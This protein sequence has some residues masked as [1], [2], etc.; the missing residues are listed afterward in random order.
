MTYLVNAIR[1]TGLIFLGLFAGL[2]LIFAIERAEYIIQRSIAYDVSPLVFVKLFVFYVPRVMSYIVPV[3]VVTAVYFVVLSCRENR[4]FLA[5]EA[6][7]SSLKPITRLTL[8]LAG[9]AFLVNLLI[10]GYIMPGAAH[11][12]RA[13]TYKA[14]AAFAAG[15]PRSGEFMT[16]GGNVFQASRPDARGN[17][18]LRVFQFGEDDALDKIVV[19]SCARLVVGQGGMLSNMCAAN[20][21]L[22]NGA[23]FA[24]AP[25]EGS[26]TA[27]SDGTVTT[28]QAS[29]SSVFFSLNSIVPA[30]LTERLNERPLTRL[31]ALDR[32][33]EFASAAD[34]RKGIIDLSSA[35]SSA[36]AVVLGVVAVALTSSRSRFFV[37]PGAV[38]ATMLINMTAVSGILVPQDVIPGKTGVLVVLASMLLGLGLA[39]HAIFRLLHNR[40]LVP[41]LRRT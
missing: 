26:S 21:Y 34:A 6:A 13:E 31:F 7:G 23:P 36:I 28:L 14:R 2:L 18:T 8:L 32:K 19:S 33:G 12:Y 9:G 10:T 25:A 41:G 11:A 38:A 15:G 35:F 3:S 24:P 29:E 4:E 39:V 16:D 30:L 37:L 5:L 22:F 40:L 27:G 20:A 17:R 1:R